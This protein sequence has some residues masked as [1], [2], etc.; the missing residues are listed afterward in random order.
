MTS[1]P[2]VSVV[3]GVYNGE[4]ELPATLDSIF[5][6]Q[7]VEFECIVVDDGSKD[8]TWS[9]LEQRSAHEPRLRILRLPRGGLT[10]ALIAGCAAAKG[11][12]IARHD[13]GDHSLPSRL[14]EQSE[15]L[16]NDDSLSFVSSWSEY[17]GPEQEPL[18]VAKGSMSAEAPL[19]ILDESEQWGV[20]DGPT[21]HGATMFRRSAYEIVGGYRRE[22]Y[23][24]QDWDLWYRLAA[25]GRFCM[26]P[27]VLY[28][29]KLMP[30]SISVS[31]KSAQNRV[32]SL[33]RTALTRRLEEHSEDDLIK[34]ISQI[35]PTLGEKTETERQAAS[36]GLYFIGEC[37]R[38]NQDRRARRYLWQAVQN[39]PMNWRAWARFLQSILARS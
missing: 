37:L 5:S 27:K 18:H 8:A 12:F 9:I 31:G 4:R 3:M 21:H 16:R 7:G 15:L 10:C 32:A 20:I 1:F 23:Y 30:I 35:R 25:V 17:V 19:W 39:D 13:I 14:S 24:G 26:I 6:Q 33:S 22:F 29:P 28:I 36:R 2:L 11:E 38:R 34:E